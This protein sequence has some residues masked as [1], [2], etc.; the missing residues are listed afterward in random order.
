MKKLYQVQVQSQLQYYA[1]TIIGDCA[2][3]LD[4][5]LVWMAN[6]DNVLYT[7]WVIRLRCCSPALSGSK[8]NK[9]V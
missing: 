1:F 7:C 5:R 9:L 3:K 8:L 4:G 6:E 2:N